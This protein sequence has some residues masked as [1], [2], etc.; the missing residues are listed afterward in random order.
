MIS[1][2]VEDFCL[3]IVDHFDHSVKKTGMFSLPSSGL[4]ELPAVDNVPVEDQVFTVILL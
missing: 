3:L 1:P 4:F 2:K